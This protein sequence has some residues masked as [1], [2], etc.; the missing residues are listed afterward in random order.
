VHGP[1]SSSF[2]VA[3]HFD[4]VGLPIAGRRE[5]LATH[6]VDRLAERV[7]LVDARGR[8]RIGW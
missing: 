5:S 7:R 3:E 4:E 2:L 8:C 1:E 6:L